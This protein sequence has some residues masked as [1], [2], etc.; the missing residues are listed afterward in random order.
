MQRELE[1]Y[2]FK[3]NN[4][5]KVIVSWGWTDEAAKEAKRRG[6]VLWDFRDILRSIASACRQRGT[7]FTDDTL[8]TIQLFLRSAPP[9]TH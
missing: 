1:K 6:V 4:Y 3:G 2:G 7:Y 5:E 8:R 9:S